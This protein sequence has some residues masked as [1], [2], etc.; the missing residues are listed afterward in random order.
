MRRERPLR[1]GRRSR[2]EAALALF[3]RLW[4]GVV[5]L[6][7]GMFLLIRIAPDVHGKP[8]FEDEA[9]VGQISVHGLVSVLRTVIWDRGGAPLHFVLA[10]V[11]L[12]GVDSAAA[13]RWLSAVAAVATLPVAFDLGRR[14]G[15]RQIGALA[16]VVCA[17]SGLLSVVGSFGRMYALYA[18]AGA[19]ACDLFV[20][21]AQRPTRESLALATHPYGGILLA[22]EAVVALV[23]WRGRPPRAALPAIA[24]LASAAVFLIADV[25]LSQRFDVGGHGSRAVATPSQALDQLSAAVRGFSGGTAL[26]ALLFAA[27]VAVGLGWCVRNARSPVAGLTIAIPLDGSRVDASILRARIGPP[28]E[29]GIFRDWLVLGEPEPL[30]SPGTVICRLRT[31]LGAVDDALTPS[32]AARHELGLYL[33]VNEKALRATGVRC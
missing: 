29:V 15:G 14:V 31:A 18:L 11:V 1:E 17:S 22:L 12:L 9:I 23:A 20:R 5:V 19:L 27:P 3:E 10:H 4:P 26:L 30:D 24:I 6:A 21:A 28:I 32:A 25:R 16:A 13:L 33:S 8:L 7:A 2:D